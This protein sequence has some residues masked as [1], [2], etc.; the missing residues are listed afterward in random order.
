MTIAMRSL[1]RSMPAA[2]PLFAVQRRKPALSLA[3][4]GLLLLAVATSTGLRPSWASA[5]SI[6]APAERTSVSTI[7]AADLAPEQVAAGRGCPITG[8]LV[9]NGNPAEVAAA[10]CGGR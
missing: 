8:D 10:L 6:T 9:A 1:Q 4:G 5:P 7:I 3:F 2:A